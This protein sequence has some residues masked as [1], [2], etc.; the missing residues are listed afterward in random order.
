MHSLYMVE[1]L[2]AAVVFGIIASGCS[3]D[4]ASESGSTTT[5]AVSGVLQ[6]I[7]EQDAFAKV[8]CHGALPST[9][10]NKGTH[11]QMFSGYTS[12]DYNAKVYEKYVAENKSDDTVYIVAY[13]IFS[14][15]MHLHERDL[16]KR[17][18]RSTNT[19]LMNDCSGVTEGGVD[20]SVYLVRDIDNLIKDD[21]PEYGRIECVPPIVLKPGD[22][23]E[24]EIC[25]DDYVDTQKMGLYLIGG[26]G[27][28]V[29]N[30]KGGHSLKAL[31]HADIIRLDKSGHHLPCIEH[32]VGPRR[33]Q[34]DI[35]RINSRVGEN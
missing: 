27:Y 12:F 15:E 30:D 14:K 32:V 31:P 24:M 29:I 23:Y 10:N 6:K 20:Y 35:D 22:A 2:S 13:H 25:I 21:A 1:I 26:F 28:E 19:L 34:E 7:K 17:D 5:P 33:S 3:G 18:K 8:V 16:T 9:G 4:A 11:I